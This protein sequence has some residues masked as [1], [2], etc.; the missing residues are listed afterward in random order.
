MNRRFI[1]NLLAGALILTCSA[2][3]AA[4]LSGEIARSDFRAWSTNHGGTWI[5]FN[6]LVTG[7]A[8]R[9][10][11]TNRFGI[12]FATTSDP[13]GRPLAKPTPVVT[14]SGYAYNL[15]RITFVGSPCVGCLDDKS[16]DYEIRFLKP[17]RWAGLQRYWKGPTVTRFYAS[18]GDL[19]HESDGEGFHGWL[20]DSNDTDFWVSRIEI[21]TRAGD[22]AREVGYSD[23]LIF[24]T[25]NI[26]RMLPYLSIRTIGPAV[27]NAIPARSFQVDYRARNLGGTND[28]LTVTNLIGLPGANNGKARDSDSLFDVK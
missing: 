23:D 4:G 7:T 28:F 21:T 22:A 20:G 6:Q 14:S 15:G 9:N 1:L 24:G 3:R 11:W 8:L 19:L 18:D 26:S 17:Q 16:C 2:S 13:T 27:A 10:Q 5:H 12:T 25:N